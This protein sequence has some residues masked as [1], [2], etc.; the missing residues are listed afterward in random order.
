[1]ER[2]SQVS[3]TRMSAAARKDKGPYPEQRAWVGGNLC[4]MPEAAAHLNCSWKPCSNATCFCPCGTGR[5]SLGIGTPQM[6]IKLMCLCH[7]CQLGRCPQTGGVVGPPSSPGSA[8]VHSTG[9]LTWHPT[10]S[11]QA[12]WSLPFPYLFIFLVDCIIWPSRK[13][14]QEVTQL[15]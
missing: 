1:M 13:S 5:K 14:L 7:A 6:K 9:N 2:H 11:G 12:K 10:R 15:K 3:P 4:N 8:R